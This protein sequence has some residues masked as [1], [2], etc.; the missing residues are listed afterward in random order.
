MPGRMVSTYVA[1]LLLNRRKKCYIYRLHLELIVEVLSYLSVEDIARVRRIS[2]AISL[3]THHPIIWRRFLERLNLPILPTRPNFLYTIQATD[4]E[5][6]QLVTR[7]ICADDNWRRPNPKLLNKEI[8]CAYQ[9]VM[10]MKLLP[11]GRFKLSVLDL[12]VL[13]GSSERARACTV[14][15]EIDSL[16]TVQPAGEVSSELIR[17]VVDHDIVLCQK[18]SEWGLSLDP[19][20]WSAEIDA[21]SPYDMLYSLA[22]QQINLKSLELLSDPIVDRNS[23][24]FTEKMQEDPPPFGNQYIYTWEQTKPF[25]DASLFDVDGVCYVAHA[26][27]TTVYVADVVGR[28]TTSFHLGR[29]SHFADCD[30]QIRTMRVLP[31]QNR[32][33]VFRTIKVAGVLAGQAHDAH[34]IEV[35]DILEVDNDTY[36][37][38]NDTQRIR[39]EHA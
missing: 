39:T 11:G 37:R 7:T 23:P 25:V 27:Q 4:F 24:K 36:E 13:F 17:D 15:E 3:I 33:L 22:V 31:K 29:D 18:S 6:E 5:I 8:A 28:K 38:A 12:C 35:F 21:D 10:E 9:Q 2:K 1:P 34:M 26:S 32:V 14:G 20:Q 16:E 30:H 19:A